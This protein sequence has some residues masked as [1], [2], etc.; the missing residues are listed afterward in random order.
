[1]RNGRV[2]HLRPGLRAPAQA[3]LAAA[4]GLAPGFL[5]GRI[6]WLFGADVT[7]GESGG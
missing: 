3:A 2:Y 5:A 1:V 7:S 4:S 6:D